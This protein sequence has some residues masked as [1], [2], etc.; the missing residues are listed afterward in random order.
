MLWPVDMYIKPF[1]SCHY[2]DLVLKVYDCNIEEKNLAVD[3]IRLCSRPTLVS[4]AILMK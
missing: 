4:K 3:Q 2:D 1:Q